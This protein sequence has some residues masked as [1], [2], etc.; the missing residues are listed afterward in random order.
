LSLGADVSF[1]G[2]GEVGRVAES[3][4]L[5]EN[6]PKRHSAP[7]SITSSARSRNENAVANVRFD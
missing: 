6:D 2:E 5:V 1:Q 3:A 4:A 7:H